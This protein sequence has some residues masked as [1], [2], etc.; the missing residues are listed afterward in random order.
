MAKRGLNIYKRKDGRWEGRFIKDRINGK[1]V[2]GYVLGKSYTETKERL[3]TS[4][5]KWANDVSEA[6][7]NKTKLR[8]LGNEWLKKAEAFLKESTVAKYN[9]YC[10]RYIWDV[11][12]DYDI[13]DIT[14]AN[15]TQFFYDLT[16][17]GGANGNGLQRSTVTSVSGILRNI[18]NYA[19]NM[20]YTVNYRVECVEL[21]PKRCEKRVFDVDEQVRLSVYLLNN[22]NRI[23]LGIYLSLYTGIRLGE[24]CALRWED[25]SLT[26]R[27]MVISR[28]MQ[29]IH[30]RSRETN[31]TKI[32]I[33]S[34]KSESSKRVIPLTD[35][36]CE[37]LQPFYCEHGY[38][39]TGD[40]TKFIEPR[41]MQY[42]FKTVLEECCIKD[43]NFHALRHTFATQS[44]ANGFDVK[45]L[46]EILGHSGVN[47]TLGNYVHPS[48]ETK[49]ANMIKV[50]T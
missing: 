8:T 47:I 2:Y 9:E 10:E 14:N 30:H 37:K 38:L 44:M 48:L 13:S 24:L 17:S 45:C 35:A 1:Y 20:G 22:M 49:R 5:T 19:K 16:T 42:R 26:E 34:P 31:K 4:R 28:T 39:L 36:L 21:K 50:G 46:S 3:I 12:G 25:I 6:L 23:N 40:D 7:Q 33:T 32:V 18:R 11:L 43:A 41:R 29:R 27:K 15:L